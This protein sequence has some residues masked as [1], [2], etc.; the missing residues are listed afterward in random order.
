MATAKRAQ[1]H[2]LIGITGIKEL[3]QRNRNSYRVIYMKRRATCSIQYALILTMS[4]K[5]IL[6]ANCVY[7]FDT[8][9][10]ALKQISR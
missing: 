7:L 1:W 5:R 8:L 2:V 4:D 9:Q 10:H 3:P 6:Y